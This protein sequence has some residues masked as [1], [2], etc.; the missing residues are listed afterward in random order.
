[1][2]GDPL[3]C[4]EDCNRLGADARLE[5]CF[6]QRVGHRVVMATDLNMVVDVDPHQLPLGLCIRRVG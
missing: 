6:D 5:W 4:V 2:R 1:M 3:A